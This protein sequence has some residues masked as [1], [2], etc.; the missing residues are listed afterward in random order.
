[1]TTRRRHR[2][3]TFS[4]VAL[5]GGGLPPPEQLMDPRLRRIDEVL[6][7]PA[8]VDLVVEA[9]RRRRPQ[10]AR[11]GRPS[12]PAE[13][14]LRMLVLKHLRGW[15]YEELQW[16]VTGNLV[17]RRFCRIDAGVVPDAKT[18][19]RY[20]QLLDEEI[21]R[22]VFDRI[23][24]VAV[25]AGV[26]RGKRM[27]IDTT[28]VEA[29]IHYPSDSTL[30][31]D[32][33][34]VASREVERLEEAGVELP[35]RRAG[36]RRSVAHRL[37]EIAQALRRKGDAAREAI[38][39]PYRGLLRIAGRLIRQAELAVAA[40][41][42]RL[43]AARGRRARQ[44]WS[45]AS[46]LDALVPLARRVVRQTRARVLRGESR[47]EGKII[48]LFDPNARILRRGKLHKPTEFGRMVV[49]QEAEGGLVTGI[50]VT[51]A[52]DTA[53][54]VPAVEHHVAVFGHVPIMAA[55]D[56][57]F[58]TNAGELR[59][60][61]LGVRR[62]VIPHSG[63]RSRSRIAYERQRWFRRG[64]A[65]RAGGEARIGRLK[66]TFGMARSRYRGATGTARTVYWAGI[67]NNLIATTAVA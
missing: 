35:F 25:E 33:I 65:W 11:R 17:Y 23:V 44:I 4:D 36:V 29:D 13:V 67:A 19:V 38:K 49:V 18:M 2:Q 31:E 46:K 45:S 43:P 3:V 63:Y 21:L 12:T 60:R 40:A 24:T 32:V 48:S 16:E 57:G 28:V 62:P 53:L 5:F 64:R 22:P 34:R 52:H 41:H 55:T 42:E 59:I 61:E 47:S 6:D 20:G 8:L 27:R 56:R 1:M 54:L 9:L 37:R 39:R 58:F 15:S 7:D 30:C 14:V 26:S 66:H 51:D 10:S 50:G